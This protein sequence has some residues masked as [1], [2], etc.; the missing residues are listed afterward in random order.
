MML[1][2]P[3]V[4]IVINISQGALEGSFSVIRGT[5]DTIMRNQLNIQPKV[6]NWVY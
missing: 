6:T 4:L 2:A 3:R 1:H 5:M